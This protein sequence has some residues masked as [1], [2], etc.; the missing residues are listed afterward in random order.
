MAQYPRLSLEARTAQ[1]AQAGPVPGRGLSDMRP[2]HPCPWQETRTGKPDRRASSLAAP[3]L[4]SCSS[5]ALPYRE[6]L[7]GLRGACPGPLCQGASRTRHANAIIGESARTPSATNSACPRL[8]SQGEGHAAHAC[9]VMATIVGRTAH[10]HAGVRQ[11]RQGIQ[12]RN[13]LASL[14]SVAH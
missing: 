3:G 4:R 9:G 13:A 11:I 1:L 14:L 2:Q 7:A 12:L 6:P 10:R 8:P 5:V